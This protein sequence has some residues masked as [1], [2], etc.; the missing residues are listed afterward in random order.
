MTV[1]SGKKAKQIAEENSATYRQTAR[2]GIVMN[3][4]NS[5]AR[6]TVEMC[7]RTNKTLVNPIVDW[8]DDEVWEFIR[9]YEI[10]YCSLYDEGWKRLGC[11]GCPMGGG[12]SMEREFERWP[13]IKKMYM[14]AFADMIEGR[15]RDGL[16][17]EY[18]TSPDEV[19]AW[20]TGKREGRNEGQIRMEIERLMEED[21]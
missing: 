8:T 19:M 21:M 2:G 13:S 7:Y 11:V 1:M 9:S 17:T 15:L 3:D 6:R 14:R 5:E 16:K 18:F 20:W 4:D 10:P 12:D